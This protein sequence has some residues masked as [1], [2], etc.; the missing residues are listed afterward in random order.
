MRH[1]LRTAGLVAFFLV[2]ALGMHTPG[3]CF[4]QQ[5][6]GGASRGPGLVP[7]GLGSGIHGALDDKTLIDLP[8]IGAQTNPFSDWSFFSDEYVSPRPEE[9]ILACVDGYRGDAGLTYM[10]SAG[11]RASLGMYVVQGMETVKV[12]PLIGIE[13]NRAGASRLSALIGLPET[14]LSLRIS[15]VLTSRIGLRYDQ[16]LTELTTALLPQ[17]RMILPQ[18]EM[19][20]GF[21]L[22]RTAGPACVLTWGLQYS[23]YGETDDARET[24]LGTFLKLVY[25]L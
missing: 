9:E 16:G 11:W 23:R 17:E 13:W 5:E 24:S 8:K 3:N 2:F 6:L 12:L 20:A 21:Y 25:A 14:S 4:D 18:E 22:D 15:E 7:P 10:I 19:T 1:P